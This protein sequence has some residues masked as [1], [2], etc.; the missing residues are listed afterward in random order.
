MKSKL[1]VKGAIFSMACA[2][3]L[4]CSTEEPYVYPDART[5]SD[6]VNPSQKDPG[7]A[8]EFV[9]LRNKNGTVRISLIGAYIVSATIYSLF[10][11][12]S[13]FSFGY[14]VHGDFVFLGTN[15]DPNFMGLPF[16]V[17]SALEL[18]F[19]IN[20][21]H[22]LG[23]LIALIFCYVSSVFI[24]VLSASRGSALSFVLSNLIVLFLYLTRKNK[25]VLKKIVVLTLVVVAGFLMVFFFYEKFGNAFARILT[26]GQAGSDNGRFELWQSGIETWKSNW[27]IGG[28]FYANFERFGKAVHNTYIE[29]LSESGI[30][31]F[32]LL[33]PY[34]IRAFKKCLLYNR[35]MFGALVAL[36]I[37]IAFLDALDNRVLWVVFCWIAVL[38]GR[39]D[40]P[41]QNAE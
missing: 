16:S 25:S 3:L 13:V 40:V 18:Y 12:Y 34:L 28:G 10:L 32:I 4:G 6:L 7:M 37:Q 11:I 26:I 38:P 31:G 36:L 9:E 23:T 17:A 14:K 41:E 24:V 35:Y 29:V 19:L 2:V 22:R 15:F 5:Y 8:E 1:Y 33:F 39:N 21:R 20:K 30:V 27:L